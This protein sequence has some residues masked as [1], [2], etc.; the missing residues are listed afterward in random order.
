MKEKK[1]ENKELLNE[2]EILEIKY[3]NDGNLKPF[4][5]LSSEKDIKEMQI[6]SDE[7][8]LDFKYNE[9]KISKEE[10]DSKKEQLAF[11]LK[12]QNEVYDDLI[13][14][15]IDEKEL[16]EIKEEVKDANLN[17]ID[18]KRL[19]LSLGSIAIKKI[20][21]FKQNND[22]FKNKNMEEW[23]YCYNK[24]A[25]NYEKVREVEGFILGLIK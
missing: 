7:N 18:L 12:I 17:D 8:E 5:M 23:N 11:R 19:S 24:I 14:D 25:K 22:D 9:G 3:D 15:L 1:L 16:N 2:Y 13:F 4:Y 10:Y 21:D 20:T 6:K